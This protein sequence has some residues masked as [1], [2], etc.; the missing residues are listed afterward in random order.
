MFM[1]K[2]EN[3]TEVDWLGLKLIL[4]HIIQNGNWSENGYQIIFNV[5]LSI[6]ILLLQRLKIQKFIIWKFGI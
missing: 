1:D 3:G 5:Q 2:S 4:D 6:Q